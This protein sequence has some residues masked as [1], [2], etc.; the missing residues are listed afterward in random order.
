QDN[1]CRTQLHRAVIDGSKELVQKLLSSGAAMNLGDHANNQPLHY[2]ILGNFINIVRLLLEFGA[3]FDSKGQN[4]RS[5][6][7]MSV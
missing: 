2:A 5:P 7:H 1:N 4:G 6:L 3:D